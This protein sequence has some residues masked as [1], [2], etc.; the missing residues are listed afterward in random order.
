MSDVLCMLLL[1][2]ACADRA[3][4]DSAAPPGCP[5]GMVAVG[6][7]GDVAFCIDAYE[8]V[9]EGALGSA[10][11]THAH[12]EPTEA[13]ARSAEPGELPGYGISF[14]QA[15]AACENTPVY[16]DAGALL[17]TK[18]LVSSSEWIDAGDGQ[19]GEGGLTYPF[20]DAWDP[21]AC[22]TV[23][24][25]VPWDGPQPAGSHEGCVS[26]FGVVDI[27]GN[28][29]E[30]ADPQQDL[31]APLALTW[32][33]GLGISVG[34]EDGL[35]L[36][37]P[38]VP[39]EHLLRLDVAGVPPSRLTRE[40]DGRLFISLVEDDT[41]TWDA[42]PARGFLVL[43]SAVVEREVER[44]LPVIVEP[45]GEVPGPASVRV[46]WEQDGAPLTD[47]RGCAYYVGDALGCQLN[48]PYHGHVHDFDG[49]IG[50]RCV[51]EP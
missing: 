38:L 14:D 27:V 40:E 4:D 13:T 5:E 9:Y 43:E 36:E 42:A 30:W 10:D 15:R 1:L 35:Y 48:M 31:D 50:F 29:W 6:E 47:K 33:E 8:V 25:G 49:S 45:I 51:W 21:E 11:Q 37:G 18:R 34:A 41:W 23:L 22:V 32:A 3:A 44:W 16:D 28:L 20:G 2:L 24:D 12:G 26:P 46:D 17:G 19:L 39:D 7:G